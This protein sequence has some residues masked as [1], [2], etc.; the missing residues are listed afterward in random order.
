MFSSYLLDQGEVD[1]KVYPI[2]PQLHS[3]QPGQPTKGYTGK[4]YMYTR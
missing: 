2:C 3:Q 4:N 1:H